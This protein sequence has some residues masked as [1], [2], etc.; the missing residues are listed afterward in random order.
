[1]ACVMVNGKY[2]YVN[3]NGEYVV[4]PQFDD[5]ND[6]TAAGLAAV[7]VNDKYGYVDKT[8]QY[9]I[10]PQFEAQ[11]TF[12]GDYYLSYTNDFYDDGYAVVFMTDSWG[13]EIFGIID[14]NGRYIAN[15]QFE[16]VQAY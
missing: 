13:E 8:G 6:F 15:P 7:L 4:N 11:K 10:N 3:K 1:L 9:A 16:D 5:A 12:N 2:G 14:K